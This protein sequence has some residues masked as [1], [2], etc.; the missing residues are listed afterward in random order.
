MIHGAHP[1]PFLTQ[2]VHNATRGENTLDLVLSSEPN[3]VKQIRVREPFSDHNIVICD[4]IVSIQIKEWRE[5]YY[6][7]KRG[8]ILR[9]L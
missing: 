3:M 7:F 5:M 8:N 2:H 9:G 6:D 1:R 4:I